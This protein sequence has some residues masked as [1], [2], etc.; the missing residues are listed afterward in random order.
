MI[1]L[2][3]PYSRNPKYARENYFT[4]CKFL[5]RHYCD[6]LYASTIPMFMY[7]EDE[8]H[9]ESIMHESKELI[10]KASEV[11]YGGKTAGVK[12]ELAYAER[13]NKYTKPLTKV[14]GE[15]LMRL[16]EEERATIFQLQDFIEE[17]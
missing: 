8:K 17:D 13:M 15:M 3:L 1:V 9:R 6:T 2:L 7:M 4:L 14:F 10:S 11:I 12:E 16:P 5:T